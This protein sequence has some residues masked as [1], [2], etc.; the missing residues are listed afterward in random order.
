VLI[1]TFVELLDSSLFFVESSSFL[2]A[3]DEVDVSVGLAGE[4]IRQTLLAE[5]HE[6]PHGIPFLQVRCP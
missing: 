2:G 4:L 5:M 6:P 1:Q 3:V